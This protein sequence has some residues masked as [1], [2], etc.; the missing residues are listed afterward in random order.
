MAAQNTSKRKRGPYLSYLT[1]PLHH[2][3]PRSTRKFWSRELCE[4]NIGEKRDESCSPEFTMS[5]QNRESDFHS[6]YASCSYIDTKNFVPTEGKENETITMIEDGTSFVDEQTYCINFPEEFNNSAENAEA[7]RRNETTSVEKSSPVT[8][9]NVEEP[10]FDM[11][12][13][14][15]PEIETNIIPDN[16]L[17]L[18]DGEIAFAMTVRRKHG[19]N[20]LMMKIWR[21]QLTTIRKIHL[22]RGRKSHCT[23]APGSHLV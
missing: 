4:G 20:Y 15:E 19:K 9:T 13:P 6:D 2:E 21:R 22:V 17:Y 11:C 10:I 3:V 16:S 1:N 23:M 8:G 14:E 5:S 7:Y 18:L 12:S